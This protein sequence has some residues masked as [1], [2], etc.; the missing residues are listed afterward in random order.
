MVP[1]SI[2][3]LDRCTG[4]YTMCVG[5][6]HPKFVDFAPTDSAGTKTKKRKRGKR[7]TAADHNK[8][9]RTMQQSKPGA[10][11]LSHTVVD[12]F[13]GCGGTS[14][15]FA[16]AG[17]N[18]VCAVD[19]EPAPLKTFRANFPS[20]E[21]ITGDIAER[22]VQDQLVE[23]HSGVDCVIMCPPCQG[24]SNQNQDKDKANDPRNQLPLVAAELVVR[25]APK[26]VFMEE[27][28]QCVKL[29]PELTKIFESGG[30]SVE[31]KVLYASDYGVPQRRKRF[32]LIATKPGVAFEFPAPNGSKVTAGEALNQ[33]PIP[34]WGNEVSETALGHIERRKKGE[35][36][37]LPGGGYEITDLSR[38][39]FTITTQCRTATGAFTIERDGRYYC[40]S[41]QELARL[42]SYPDTFEFKG[43][44]TAIRMQIGNSVPPLLAQAIASNIKF[45]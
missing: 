27:V 1:F 25:M 44:D 30:Y 33:P 19:L 6:K 42:H 43:A 24:L 14:C 18:I 39:C 31:H 22:G 17:Y 13:A 32:I 23:K 41:P 12:L 16:A 29:V 11:A 38:P 2:H 4:P 3:E 15:G 7:K 8:Q 40:M 35:V 28:P 9:A 10:T 21:V 34:V 37:R 36:D 45:D 20:T 26:A 5:L